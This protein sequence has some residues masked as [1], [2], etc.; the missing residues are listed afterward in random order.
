[1]QHGEA[2]E[3]ARV[4]ALGRW[5]EEV[6][7][8]GAPWLVRRL[9]SEDLGDCDAS[10]GLWVPAQ[11]WVVLGGVGVAWGVSLDSHGVRLEAVSDVA[12]DRDGD[13]GIKGP[14][15]ARS[16]VKTPRLTWRRGAP[17]VFPDSGLTGAAVAVVFQPEAGL[18]RAWVCAREAEVDALA[19]WGLV[20]EPGLTLIGVVGDWTAACFAR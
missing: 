10:P 6:W 16:G 14:T 8:P 5:R 13:R 11:L 19:E 12:F 4:Q 17:G 2:V 3:V 9:S 18:A 1:M 7:R 15:P 20:P